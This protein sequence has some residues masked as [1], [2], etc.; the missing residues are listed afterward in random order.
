MCC[1]VLCGKEG[2]RE[3][4]RSAKGTPS[5]GGGKGRLRHT[6]KLMLMGGRAQGFASLVVASMA[7]SALRV[8]SAD[9]GKRL[10]FHTW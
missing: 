2:Q 5:R 7:T 9:P 4:T 3:R 8:C 6:W 1:V 10:I